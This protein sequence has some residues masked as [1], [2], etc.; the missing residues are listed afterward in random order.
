MSQPPDV[1]ELEM[2]GIVQVDV[3]LRGAVE[4]QRPSLWAVR[5]ADELGRAVVDLGR[6][7]R[8]RHP[9]PPPLHPPILPCPSWLPCPPAGG[10]TRVRQ[11][12]RGARWRGRVVH[13]K[14]RLS[15]DPRPLLAG[16][17]RAQTIEV[18]ERRPGG[19]GSVAPGWVS[20]SARAER[21]MRRRCLMALFETAL[22]ETALF[23]TALLGTAL[24]GTA[25][26]ETALREI[27]LHGMAL[28]MAVLGVAGVVAGAGARGLL[29]RMRRG[30]R[31]PPP[32]CELA[33]AALWAA[34]GAAWAAGVLPAMWLPT[35]LA[36]GW[37]AVAASAVDLRHRR[38]PNALTVPALPVALLLLLPVGPAAVV[39]G[40]GGAAVALAM[41]A[42]GAPGR[43][44]GRGCG[45]RQ[46]GRPAG[47]G[48][49]GG[50][51]AGA[52]ARR[53]A[54]RTVHGLHRGR[55]R[56]R[57]C[58]RF[59]DGAGTRAGGRKR[60][61]ATGGGAGRTGAGVGLGGAHRAARAVDARRHLAGH[62]AGCWRWVRRG[63]GPGG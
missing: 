32:W 31:I 11:I 22:F 39:R 16:D 30:T 48:P 6:E 40:A 37:L 44:A 15:T 49:G 25:S 1:L 55:G 63:D 5:V 8:P 29:R 41:N 4:Q 13:L 9:Q 27:A 33:V 26:S 28:P 18:I 43:P 34:A 42:R 38:L 20:P 10:C 21:A 3:R 54:G 51:L 53:R 35:V 62:G 17:V 61:V 36:L 56:G 58:R 12:R 2:R 7:D 50:G 52:R 46:A 24:L 45:R 57:C 59:G 19:V 60:A 14:V 47:G 23:E